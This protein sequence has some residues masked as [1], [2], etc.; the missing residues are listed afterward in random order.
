M[1]SAI[2]II[3]MVFY[4]SVVVYA[5]AVTLQATTHLSKWAAVLSVGVVCT[6]YCTIGKWIC[7]QLFITPHDYTHVAMFFYNMNIITIIIQVEWKQLS[8]RM[9]SNRC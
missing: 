3:Q 9:S 1:A 6:F 4:M 7:P 8:G 5:P 2:F